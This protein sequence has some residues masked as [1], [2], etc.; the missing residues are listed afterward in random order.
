MDEAKYLE[1]AEVAFKAYNEAAGGKTWDGKDIPPFSDVG[2]KVRAN[3]VAAVKAA[4]DWVVANL[5]EVA[6]TTGTAA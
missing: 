6:S 3:W 2:D 5:K 1:L 4:G